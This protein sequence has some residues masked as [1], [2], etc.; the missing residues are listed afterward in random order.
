MDVDELH[1]EWLAMHIVGLMGPQIPIKHIQNWTDRNFIGTVATQRPG[2]PFSRKYSLADAV[3]VHAMYACTHSGT[4]LPIALQV[5]AIA[6]QRLIDLNDP[7][8]TGV[9]SIAIPETEV[10]F[11]CWVAGEGALVGN[12][13][14]HAEFTDHL[15]R[16]LRD[17][18]GSLWMVLGI[19]ALIDKLWLQYHDPGLEDLNSK[20]LRRQ[21]KPYP[22][23][24][25]EGLSQDEST[26]VTAAKHPHEPDAHLTQWRRERPKPRG[27]GQ[28]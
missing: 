1:R 2:R 21:L 20:A 12:F 7:M 17:M 22:K 14:S 11:T 24:L 27:R 16:R 4:T 15:Y 9:D 5:G 18:H 3:Q 6:R 10:L 13:V 28:V 8:S 25:L 23:H 19:D 26:A